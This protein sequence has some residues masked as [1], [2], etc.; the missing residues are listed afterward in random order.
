MWNLNDGRT[1]NMTDWTS[2][3]IVEG[4]QVVCVLD[5]FRDSTEMFAHLRNWFKIE[6]PEADAT[7]AYF[8]RNSI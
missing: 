4:G 3:E 5:Y 7:R 2:L 1:I 8:A 6:N